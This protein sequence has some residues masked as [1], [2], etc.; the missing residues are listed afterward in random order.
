[1]GQGTADA[2][3]PPSRGPPSKRQGTADSTSRRASQSAQQAARDSPPAFSNDVDMDRMENMD[4][5]Q[6]Q[7]LIS[8]GISQN[9]T[10]AGFDAGYDFDD[11]VGPPPVSCPMPPMPRAPSADRSGRAPSPRRSVTPKQDMH[12]G[13]APERM[14]TPRRAAELRQNNSEYSQYEA[15]NFTEDAYETTQRVMAPRRAVEAPQH[16]FEHEAPRSMR[17]GDADLDDAWERRIAAGDSTPRRAMG[18]DATP[19]R[20]G[21]RM[22]EIRAAAERRAFGGGGGRATPSR[23]QYQSPFL[24]QY[25]SAE[26]NALTDGS[27]EREVRMNEIREMTARRAQAAG[28]CRGGDHGYQ[29]KHFYGGRSGGDNLA[30]NLG[31]KFGSH[32]ILEQHHLAISN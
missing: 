11:S 27:H 3:P 12:E 29:P 26:I 25:Q 22:A 14:M 17:T 2:T 24:D 8:L 5:A 20:G 32:E 1:M 4:F 6:I 15:P 19:R 28:S 7:K 30:S 21:G 23:Q 13:Q 31:L 18:S 10:D 16:Q 9:E